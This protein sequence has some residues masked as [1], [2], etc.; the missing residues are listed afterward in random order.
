[1]H[2]R[3][4]DGYQLTVQVRLTSRTV[5]CSSHTYVAGVCTLPLLLQWAKNAPSTNWR[6]ERKGGSPPPGERGGGYRGGRDS[7][8]AG[9]RDRDYP[10]RRRS[11]S[12][13]RRSNRSPSPRH[14]A[15]PPP[16]GNTGKDERDGD[17][18]AAVNPRDEQSPSAANGTRRDERDISPRA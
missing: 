18:P 11:P 16:A 15:S 6:Y 17:D 13:P 14:A 1:M 9:G 7:R 4:V 10:S 3:R 12:P 2:G 8:G 5:Q